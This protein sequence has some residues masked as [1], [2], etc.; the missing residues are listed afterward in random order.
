MA[1]SEGLVASLRRVRQKLALPAS[2]HQTGEIAV[3]SHDL[4]VIDYTGEKRP[5]FQAEVERMK[6]KPTAAAAWCSPT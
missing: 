2:E 6:R 1:P 5:V 3:S 4:V